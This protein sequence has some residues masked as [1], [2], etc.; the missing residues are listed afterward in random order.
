MQLLYPTSIL[1][2][3]GQ[4]GLFKLQEA[5]PKRFHYYANFHKLSIAAQWASSIASLGS[6]Y[7]EL[8]K[9]WDLTSKALKH[10][11]ETDP[12]PTFRIVGM[13]VAVGAIAAFGLA[14]LSVCQINDFYNRDLEIQRLQA[15][16]WPQ[17]VEIKRSLGPWD[18]ILRQAAY[19]VQL[20][21]DTC[22]FG[23]GRSPIPLANAMVSLHNILLLAKRK[24][25]QL[26]ATREFDGTWVLE[27]RYFIARLESKGTPGDE[28]SVCL[29]AMSESNPTFSFCPNHPPKEHDQCT[30]TYAAS[31]LAILAQSCGLSFRPV[32]RNSRLIHKFQ[33]KLSERK[34]PSCPNCREQPNG[35]TYEATIRYNIPNSMINTATHIKWMKA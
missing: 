9:R 13:G 21:A 18:Q 26:V 4:A 22:T 23:L 29:N 2:N 7:H 11:N 1:L 24:W 16:G 28:C 25:V 19:L 34:K 30:V 32:M 12:I 3:I 6:L 17:N 14:L 10:L 8:D 15:D 20:V 31:R 27:L 5:D 33:V 35:N